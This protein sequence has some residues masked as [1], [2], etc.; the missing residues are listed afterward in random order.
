[1]EMSFTIGMVRKQ[2]SSRVGVDGTLISSTSGELIA[3]RLKKKSIEFV[4][5]KENL[6]DLVWKDRPA[7]P[8][9]PVVYLSTEDAGESVQ[10]KVKRVLQRILI[11]YR[12]V[13]PL[14]N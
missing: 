4:C 7:I 13:K 1:M 10:S 14:T 8:C 5:E 3:T 2:S 9:T 12:F 11:H 6:V